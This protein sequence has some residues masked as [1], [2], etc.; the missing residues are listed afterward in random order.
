MEELHAQCRDE[1]K[2]VKQ[3]L[4]TKHLNKEND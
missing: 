4:E 2:T 1:V 3:D